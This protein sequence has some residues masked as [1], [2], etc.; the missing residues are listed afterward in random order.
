MK[1]IANEI[2]SFNIVFHVEMNIFFSA[3]S[4][5]MAM[6][7]HLFEKVHAFGDALTRF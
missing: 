4:E 1:Y 3:Y 6:I 7:L 2:A 5:R